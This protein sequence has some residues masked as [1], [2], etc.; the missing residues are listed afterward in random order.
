MA[1]IR[2][3]SI[4]NPN[5]CHCLKETQSDDASWPKRGNLQLLPDVLSVLYINIL[6]IMRYRSSEREKIGKVFSFLFSS[7]SSSL[8]Y[9]YIGATC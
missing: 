1:I 8:T 2:E 7:S 4:L 6:S 9:I 5:R 3:F